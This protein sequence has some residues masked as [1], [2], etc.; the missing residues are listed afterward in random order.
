MGRKLYLL[1]FPHHYKQTTPSY[2]YQTNV[3]NNTLILSECN[4]LCIIRP[5]GGDNAEVC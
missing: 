3:K 2:L 5:Q 1:K 4:T